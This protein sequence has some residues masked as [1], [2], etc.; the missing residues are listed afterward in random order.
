[1]SL[2]DVQVKMLPMMLCFH[3]RKLRGI[4]TWTREEY[5]EVYVQEKF[6]TKL[7]QGIKKE[8]GRSI[9]VN[10]DE[11]TILDE[12]ETPILDLHRAWPMG[13]P[14]ARLKSWLEKS[15]KEAGPKRRIEEATKNYLDK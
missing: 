1:M 13:L 6:I 8:F 12:Y 9:P 10:D 14:N 7:K 4:D 3:K 15:Q 2:E 5:F 11:A